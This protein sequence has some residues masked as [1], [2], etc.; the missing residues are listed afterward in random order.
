MIHKITWHDLE[1]DRIPVEFYSTCGVPQTRMVRIGMPRIPPNVINGVFYLY[2]S[3]ADALDGKEPGGT[4][5]IVRYDGTFTEEVPGHHF[6][7]VTN[8]HVACQ[9]DYDDNGLPLSPYSVVRLNTKAGGTDVIGFKPED[10]HFLPDKYDVAVVPLMLDETL[11]DVSSIST[12]QFA[13]ESTAH[14]ERI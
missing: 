12:F 5:F 4:G 10:W 8:W 2:Q 7:G 6:Y 9:V 11:H 14:L 3:Q 13:K 1:F